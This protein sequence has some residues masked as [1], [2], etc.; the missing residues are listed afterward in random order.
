MIDL[1]TGILVLVFGYIVR[2]EHRI[3]KI[4]TE[5]KRGQNELDNN[6]ENSGRNSGSI[7]RR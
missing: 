2:I 1:N 7:K 3:T 6:N 5:L 4:E